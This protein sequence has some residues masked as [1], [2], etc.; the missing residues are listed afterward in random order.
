[1]LTQQAKASLNQLS[2]NT[3]ELLVAVNKQRLQESGTT[4][5]EVKKTFSLKQAHAQNL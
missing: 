1:M 3:G 5:Y 2:G 4:S